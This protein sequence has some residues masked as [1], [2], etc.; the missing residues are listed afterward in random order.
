MPP[1]ARLRARLSRRQPGQ[2][3]VELVAA[4]PFVL[5]AAAVA[6][7]L[8]LAGEAA[9]LSANAARAAARAEAVGRDGRAAAVSALPR[10]FR[11]GLQ[12]SRSP[13]RAVRVRIHMPLLVRGWTTPVEI[14][15]SAGLPTGGP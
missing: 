11:A 9:W 2:A 6:W 7:Q 8:A 10:P 1:L 4:V 14:S 13:G 12:V 5:L 15:A 3:S